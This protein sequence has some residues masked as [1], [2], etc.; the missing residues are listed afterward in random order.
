MA[1]KQSNTGVFERAG[2]ALGAAN[3]TMEHHDYV[4]SLKQNITFAMEDNKKK[5]EENT[6]DDSKMGVNVTEDTKNFVLDVSEDIKELQEIEVGGKYDMGDGVMGTYTEEDVRNAGD[7]IDQLNLQIRNHSD[8]VEEKVNL[9]VQIKNRGISKSASLE[10][11]QNYQLLIGQ[12]YG[13]N[14][15]K[16]KLD[17]DPKS[18]S[19]GQYLYYDA[20]VNKHV[21]ISNFNTGSAYDPTLAQNIETDENNIIDFANKKAT[22]SDP[23]LWERQ[24]K[25]KLINKINGYIKE[26]PNA[27]KNMLFEEDDFQPLLNTMLKDLY[28]PKQTDTDLTDAEKAFYLQFAEGTPEETIYNVWKSSDLYDTSMEDLKK[29]E[30]NPTF[31]MKSYEEMIDKIF[32][33]AS[34]EPK[35]EEEEGALN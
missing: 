4:K 11:Q 16:Q 13:E 28:F 6:Y 34:P 22:I 24:E 8:H 32:N 31:F 23:G 12:T 9:S 14:G 30:I 29:T 20:T 15:L 33:D 18:A 21:P 1:K 19:Y 17:K 27:V 35:E 3:L 2:Y 26:N 5:E 10:Q 7:K 25:P